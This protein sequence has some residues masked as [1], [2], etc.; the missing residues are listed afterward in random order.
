MH[1]TFK[2]VGPWSVNSY[3]LTCPATGHSILIDPGGEPDT[4]SKMV[5]GSRPQAI[6]ITHGHPDHIGALAEMRQRLKVP[7]LA[8]PDNA[9]RSPVTADRPLADGEGIVVGDHRLRVYHAPGHTADQ[10]CFAVENDCHVIVGDTIFEGGPG[11]TWSPEDFRTTL[12]TLKTVVLP[13]SDDTICYPGHGPFFRLGDKRAAI[14]D[15]LE[16]DHGDFYGDAEWE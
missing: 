14:E 15:F 11:K 3:V 6:L 2:A 16:R 7:V 8:H 13:W 1:L 5:Q 4:L 9:G 10:V 12:T